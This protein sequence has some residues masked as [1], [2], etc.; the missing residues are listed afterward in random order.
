VN[1]HGGEWARPD[2][3][4]RVLADLVAADRHHD[5]ALAER[6]GKV[7]LR[8]RS[9]SVVRHSAVPRFTLGVIVAID[10]PVS[11][12]DAPPR[13][14]RVERRAGR[15]DTSGCRRAA[16]ETAGWRDRPSVLH[17]AAVVR[18]LGRIVRPP[19]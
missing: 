6:G 18:T 13:V 11:L 7:F 1:L 12:I 19:R 17:T 9:L 3:L 16:E 8:H 2:F 14:L 5:G 10:A 4:G 15:E